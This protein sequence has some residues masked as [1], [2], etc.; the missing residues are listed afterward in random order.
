MEI[1]F[2]I[3]KK[4]LI[5]AGIT[6]AL[7]IVCF[8]IGKCS[9]KIDDVDK[10]LIDNIENASILTKEVYEDLMKAGC[11]VEAAK[12]QAKLI[13]SLMQT[14]QNSTQSAEEEIKSLK[15]INESNSKVINDMLNIYKSNCN[16]NALDQM[17]EKA[18]KYEQILEEVL[19]C[20][21]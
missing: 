15:R 8:L 18:E 11:S 2:N 19:K 5:Y 20:E 21:N 3:F 12:Q 10:G 17:I 6:V 4:T 14:I 16:L 13:D 7:C 1:K 9:Q